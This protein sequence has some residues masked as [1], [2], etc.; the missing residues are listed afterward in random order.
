M[1]V[2]TIPYARLARR[3]ARFFHA[4]TGGDPVAAGLAGAAA[5]DRDALRAAA[6]ARARVAGSRD[7]V[8]AALAARHRAL[9]SPSRVLAS[10]AA[11]R[12]GACCVVA[13]QQPLLAGGPLFVAA[14]ALTAIAL[15]RE[16]EDAT[17]S[18]CVPVFWNHSDDH[19]LPEIDALDVLDD[20]G[21]LWT[22]RAGLAGGRRAA[23]DVEDAERMGRLRRELEARLPA[24][25]HALAVRGMIDATFA[26]A[27]A[28]WFTR[29]LTH[30]FGAAGLVVFEP[31]W[32]AREA[33]PLMARVLESPGLVAEA[34]EEGGRA[35]AAAGFPAPLADSGTGLFLHAEGERARIDL[36]G[37]GFTVR[38]TRW[39][40]RNLLE[41]L[42]AQPDAVTA[43]VALR[44]VVQDALLPV[45]ATVAGP[46]EAAYLAQLGPL[47]R[48]LG[49]PRSAVVPRMGVTVVPAEVARD[50]A[51][52][53]VP[54]EALLRGESV[55][56]PLPGGLTVPFAEA[57]RGLEAALGRLKEAT[58]PLGPGLAR[59][60]AK[61]RDRILESIDIF[62]GRVAEGA[63]ESAAH[64]GREARIRSILTPGGRL[65]EQSLAG[66]WMMS[67]LGMDL[68][69]RLGKALDVRAQG[70][71]VVCVE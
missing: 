13:G 17:G 49:A 54:V 34:V 35:L 6:A 22:L 5:F 38:G 33:A 25:P 57:R 32:I 26:P 3:Y 63:P 70:H 37:D 27:P 8:A 40:R 44:P 56:P 14:K 53:G 65:Q 4:W 67:R 71:Q 28:E 21:V 23:R 36:D 30:W 59:N 2:E 12:D 48:R 51:A 41:R 19:D 60:F 66:L 50:V 61:T 45:V 7:A 55:S 24:T 69:D 39:T 16:I 47:Y 18:P 9:G 42:A 62:A 29:M 46:N 58:A 31:R 43:G 64:R 11:L 52:L 15:A 1:R 20:A 10:V 68:F